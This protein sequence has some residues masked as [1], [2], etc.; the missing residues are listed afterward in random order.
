MFT[1]CHRPI[2]PS[3]LSRALANPR[4]GALATFEGW[5]RNHDRGKKVKSLD[6][7]CFEKLARKEGDRILLEAKKKFAILDARC[8]HRVGK[9]RIGDASIWIGVTAEHRADAFRA[10]QYIIDEVK[11]RVPIWKKEHYA[12]GDSG[13]VNCQTIAPRKTVAARGKRRLCVGQTP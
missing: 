11:A 2:K 5:V 6:Y 3:L 12:D 10:C 8:V 1:I 9:L 4:A 7:E 13:W